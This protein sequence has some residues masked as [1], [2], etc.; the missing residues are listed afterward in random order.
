MENIF[1][2]ND[3]I[4]GSFSVKKNKDFKYEKAK[5]NRVII[6]DKEKYQISYFTNTQV[7]HKNIELESID[8][9][10][11]DI[12]E[13]EFNNLELFTMFMVIE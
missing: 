10:I 7:F 3:I 11:I 6:D 12:L 4:K 9:S 8:F 5:I 2:P 1:I 13:N